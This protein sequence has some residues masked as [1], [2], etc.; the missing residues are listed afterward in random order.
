[1]SDKTIKSIICDC[2]EKEL[3]TEFYNEKSNCL[4]LKTINPGFQ[5]ESKL[6]FTQMSTTNK[7]IYHFCD[8]VCLN[9][10][11]NNDLYE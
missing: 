8:F 11:L 7:N 5:K 4:E 1:M 3:V 6:F 2:C 9:K 10:W